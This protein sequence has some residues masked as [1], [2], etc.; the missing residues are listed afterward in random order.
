MRPFGVL[1]GISIYAP[2]HANVSSMPLSGISPCL[3][4]Q[5]EMPSEHTNVS[6]VPLSGMNTKIYHFLQQKSI[7][8]KGLN[9]TTGISEADFE[10]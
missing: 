5:A 3:G 10:R 1:R 2:E 8:F 6:S 9:G 4:V 7:N